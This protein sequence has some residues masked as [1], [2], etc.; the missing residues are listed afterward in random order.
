MKTLQERI[1]EALDAGFTHAQLAEAAG[2]SSASVSQWKSGD[3]KALKADSVAGL[4]KLTGWSSEWWATGKGSRTV[5]RES[6]TLPTSSVTN[7]TRAPVIEWSRLGEDVYKE[8]GELGSN[9]HR[10]FA[11]IGEAGPQ[12]KLIPVVDDALA[13]RLVR[14]DLVA[15]DPENKNPKRDAVCLFR[16][17]TD[18]AFFLRRFRPLAAGAFEATGAD[19]ALDSV[20]HDLEVVGVACGGVMGSI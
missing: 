9:P 14:G 6:S 8:V 5:K 13:P 1:Q 2:K 15:I 12:T 11:P 17:K 18:G 3:T 4:S 19:G 7:L 10:E 16:S 20:R